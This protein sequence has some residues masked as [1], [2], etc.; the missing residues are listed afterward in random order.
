MWVASDSARQKHYFFCTRGI[1]LCVI[2]FPIFMV[3]AVLATVKLKAY[4]LHKNN[5]HDCVLPCYVWIKHQRCTQVCT[6]IQWKIS[7]EYCQSTTVVEMRLLLHHRTSRSVL[8]LLEVWLINIFCRSW[9]CLCSHDSG[10]PDSDIFI[11][12]YVTYVVLATLIFW[13][14]LLYKCCRACLVAWRPWL[15]SAQ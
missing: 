4:Y 9:A 7:F 13:W 3:L 1:S 15:A 6:W 8:L 5:H 2:F 14:Q 10:K 12:A 11:C